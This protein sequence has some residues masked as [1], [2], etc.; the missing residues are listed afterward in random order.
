MGY[1]Y[2][3]TNKENNKCYIGQTK[4]EPY[5]R[6]E[7]HIRNRTPIG[8][9]I[10]K[11]GRHNFDFDILEEVEDDNLDQKEIEY[12]EKFNSYYN[13]YNRTL[14]G[15]NGSG[16]RINPENAFIYDREGEIL[17]VFFETYSSEGT[18]E[19][20]GYLSK[21]D[22]RIILKKNGIK[23][24]EVKDTHYWKPIY[25]PELDEM[26]KTVEHA[27]EVLLKL[28]LTGTKDK[29]SIRMGLYRVL[30]GK[31]QKYSNLTFKYVYWL[32]CII[33]QKSMHSCQ[34]LS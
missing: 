34:T 1:I 9:A 14:G 22:L 7:Q 24:K 5:L 20:L 19:Y 25:C 28:D 15:Q 29:T 18:I 26:F 23:V 6:F 12:I 3:I 16:G 2:K 33:I 17:R 8:L 21:A 27:V 10:K 32:L 13:G 31:T 4:Q 11:N 30:T